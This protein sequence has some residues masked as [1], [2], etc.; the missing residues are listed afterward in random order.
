MSKH[1]MD[2]SGRYTPAD[3][4]CTGCNATGCKLWRDYGMSLFELQCVDCACRAS[5]IPVDVD[6]KGVR[7]G[8]VGP[9]RDIGWYVPAIPD[10]LLIGY[11]PYLDRPVDALDWWTRLPLRPLKSDAAVAQT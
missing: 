2:Y 11:L 1:T 9:T 6:E 3:Y 10:P 7:M 5:K 4:V 8:R